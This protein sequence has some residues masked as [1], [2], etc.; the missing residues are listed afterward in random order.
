MKMSIPLV[1]IYDQMFADIAPG[2]LVGGTIFPS[3]LKI[4]AGHWKIVG[5]EVREVPESPVEA[6]PE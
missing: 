4:P 2:A 3:G 1:D 6:L 5:R